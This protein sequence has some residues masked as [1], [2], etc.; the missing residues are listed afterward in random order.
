MDMTTNNTTKQE[1][2]IRTQALRAFH[3]HLVRVFKMP[4]RLALARV[5]SE[6]AE[7][8][9]TCDIQMQAMPSDLVAT[10]KPQT[11]RRRRAAFTLVELLV[12]IGIIALLISILLPVLGRARQS[13]ESVACMSNLRQIG[14]AA[15]MYAQFNKNWFPQPCP[16]SSCPGFTMS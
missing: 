2:K 9:L 11:H 3:A 15:F 5:N 7:N 1:S 12:V 13:A 8:P 10:E 4:A 14:Q 6:L 16:G